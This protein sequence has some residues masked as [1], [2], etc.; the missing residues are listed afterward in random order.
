MKNPE[1]IEASVLKYV[2]RRFL[3][4][5][6]SLL[7]PIFILLIL[8]FFIYSV[9]FLIPKY[10]VKEL[11]DLG[12]NMKGRVV[13][14]FSTGDQDDW[15]IEDDQKLYEKY[16]K[17]DR[18]WLNKFMDQNTLENSEVQHCDG[19]AA[20][21]GITVKEVWGRFY[22]KDSGIPAERSQV[23]QHSVSWALLAAVDRVLGDPVITGLKAR[24]PQAESHFKSLEPKLEWQ[25]F[26][27][28][29]RC[30]W[31]EVS[32]SGE[33]A[34]SKKFTRIYSH[35]IKL[36]S[37]VHSYEAEKI[38]YRWDKKRYFY[39]DPHTD[40]VE[41][42]IYPVFNNVTYKGPYFKKLSDLLKDNQLVKES[43]LELV[44][45]L[46]MNY[47]KEFKYSV[48]LISGN[49]AELYLDTEKSTYLLKGSPGSYLWP[50]GEN[51]TITSGYGW[52]KHPVLSG[53]SFHKGVDIA[54]PGGTPVLSAWDGKVVLSGWI[55]GYGKTVIIDHGH[56]R[57]LYAHLMSFE[58]DAGQEVRQ[59]EQIGKADSTGLSTG[60]HLHFE[61]RSGDGET[62]YH[63]PVE[64]YYTLAGGKGASN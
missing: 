39:K 4:W 36:L 13:A 42:A 30:S 10:I 14:I 6:L 56:Y 25:D 45:N 55:S 20:V 5:L 9:L 32:G 46:A 44:L 24:W 60:N 57:T 34:K 35:K 16:V 64:L 23:K 28:S 11:Q 50:V 8:F 54:V 61:V 29:Y 18:D 27:L 41:E 33:N 7:A 37:E 26:E 38:A 62:Y 43:D 12:G 59:G 40:F 19:N 15:K 49:L 47:D 63:N 21:K 31:T 3:L 1:G 2:L 22:E 48:G 17:L 52:R 58:I 51:K 53:L